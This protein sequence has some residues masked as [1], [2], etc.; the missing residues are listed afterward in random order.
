MKTYND[1]GL[2]NVTTT[3]ITLPNETR[4][5]KRRKILVL[6]SPGVGKSAIIMRF[7]DDIFLDYYDPTIH[8]TIKKLLRFNNKN[9]EL[10]IIDIDGQT[11]YTIFSFSKF[12]FGIHG[13]LLCYSIENRQSFE[14]LK[15]IN[16]KLVTLVGRDVPKVLIANKCDLLNRR[17][18]TVE[19]GKL[20]A[21]KIDCPFL[22][23]SAKAN[24]NINKIFQTTLTEINK[25]ESNVDLR[26]MTCNKLNELFV[27]REKILR[28]VSFILIFINIVYFTNIDNRSN[29]FSFRFLY[30]NRSF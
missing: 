25:F 15:F 10:E 4:S 14:L 12:S 24:T 18:I 16:S 5:S 2:N 9:V 11:E 28:K 19:E 13:Y 3:L 8:S 7:K 29:R 21:K 6:G 23:C 17:E 20:F 27:K 30:R 1:N 22:E 26:G